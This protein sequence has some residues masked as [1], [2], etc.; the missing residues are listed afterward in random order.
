MMLLITSV[1][2]L[3]HYHLYRK[4][5]AQ[6]FVHKDH[7]KAL[8]AFATVAFLSCLSFLISKSF[9]APETTFLS[10]LSASCL[11]WS[12]ITVFS[13]LLVDFIFFL[14]HYSPFSSVVSSSSSSSSSS[15]KVMTEIARS[16]RKAKLAL[17]IST[18]M[19]IVGLISASSPPEIIK[20]EVYLEK[21]PCELNGFT[22]TQLSDTHLGNTFSRSKFVEIINRVNELKPDMVVLTGDLIDAKISPELLPILE[23]LGWLNSKYGIYYVTGNHEYLA[24][25][26]AEWVVELSNRKINFLHNTHQTINT[27]SGSFVIAGVDDVS[28]NMISGHGYSLNSALEGVDKSKEIILLAHQPLVVSDAANMGVGL[29]LTGHTHG[30]QIWP[31]GYL[32]KL[33]QPYVQGLHTHYT[34]ANAHTQIYV[35]RGTGWWGPPIR[36]GAPAEITHHTLYCQTA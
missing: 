28:G 1:L 8:Y 15:T 2:F 11:G 17:L 36:V 24:G 27:P 14:A 34:N 19:T 13:F 6:T 7:P 21:F 4:I 22:I 9:A 25:S 18:T 3:I 29:V 5:I 31:F 30:G 35:S 33:A 20:T 32:V 10:L 26:A 16:R 23:P 12:I